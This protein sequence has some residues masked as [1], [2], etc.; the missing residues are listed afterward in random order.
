[1]N[2][3]YK[4]L[5][6]FLRVYSIFLVSI[7]TSKE[8]NYNK[9]E[10]CADSYVLKLLK[11]IWMLI[12]RSQQTFQLVQWSTDEE[13]TDLLGS[14]IEESR[15]LWVADEVADIRALLDRTIWFVEV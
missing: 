2:D 15:A 9:G 14:Q 3:S 7:L 8:R 12:I 13:I 4:I 5:K 1:M 11:Q 10:I 6:V